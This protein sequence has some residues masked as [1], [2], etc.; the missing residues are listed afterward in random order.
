MSK[1]VA[2]KYKYIFFFSYLY[3]LNESYYF[4]DNISVVVDELYKIDN[5]SIISMN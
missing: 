5:K 4:I 1:D 2:K 3:D